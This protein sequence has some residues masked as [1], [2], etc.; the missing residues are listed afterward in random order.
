M[1]DSIDIFS[2]AASSDDAEV[3]RQGIGFIIFETAA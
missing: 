1:P 2:A 3:R